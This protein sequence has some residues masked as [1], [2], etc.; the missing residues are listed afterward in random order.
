[1]SPR[2]SLST[3]TDPATAPPD[4]RCG[5]AAEHEPRSASARWVSWI[6]SRAGAR[7]PLAVAWLL[8]IMLVVAPLGQPVGTEVLQALALCLV[9]ALGLLVTAGLVLGAAGRPR[10]RVR[11]PTRIAVIGSQASAV[12]LSQALGIHGISAYTSLGWIA[13][14][15]TPGPELPM[16]LTLGR[17]DELASLAERHRIDL[18]L[19]GC[20]VPRMEVFD[21][22]VRLTNG[23]SV[24]VC[25]L[26]AFYEDAFGHIPV[27][28]INSAWFQYVMHPKFHPTTNR[29]KR[30]FDIAVSACLGIAVLPVL[31]LAALLIKLDGGPLLYQ[32]RRIGEK[33]RPFTM[34]KLRTMCQR[35]PEDNAQIWCSAEDPRVTRVGR[36]L[37][38]LHIDELPQLYNVLRGEMSVVGPRPEQ[39][40]IVSRL[41]RGIAFYSRRHLIKPGLAGWAQLRC[42][43]AGSD[44]GS[45]WKLCHD[46][47]YLKHQ[48]LRFDT[49]ILTRTFLGLA[50]EIARPHRLEA[51]MFATERL[52]PGVYNEPAAIHVEGRRDT[53]TH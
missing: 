3:L 50:A 32:Q 18:L 49:V 21:E 27:A 28:E 46:L 23:V 30:V 2:P 43:Y 19:I 12:A 17:L 7:A 53:I 31:L 34:Y 45:A 25:E 51:A 33:G 40:D 41:E 4:E 8:V 9:L 37:R 47:Y 11:R 44:Y 5:S 10:R 24:R 14:R 1:M 42:G 29:R 16:P 15:G 39:P 6:S 13:C 22:L 38:R 48:S 26:S 36:V 35:G 20:G 52:N